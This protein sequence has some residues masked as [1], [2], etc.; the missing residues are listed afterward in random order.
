MREDDVILVK[1]IQHGDEGAMEELV[2]RYYDQIFYYI[3]RLGSSYE[4]A[5]DVTQEVF[6]AMMKAMPTYKEQGNFKAWLYKIAHN[7]SMNHFRQNKHSVSF[8]VEHENLKLEPDISEQF[9]NQSLVRELLDSLPE[10]QSNTLILKYYHGFTANEIAKIM[11][12]PVPTV[13]SRIFQGLQKLKKR[14]KEGD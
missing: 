1:A 13:K 3:Y 10:K 9:A 7:R 14:M 2:H 12:I 11:G 8:S 5:K 6:I 4:E